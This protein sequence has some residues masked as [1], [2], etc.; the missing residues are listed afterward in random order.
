MGLGAA[1]TPPVQLRMGHNRSRRLLRLSRLARSRLLPNS[2]Q[3]SAAVRLRDAELRQE[4]TKRQGAAFDA[5]VRVV[6][7]EHVDARG[8]LV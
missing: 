4:L 2:S 7:S 6:P 8:V 1:R 3:C 5:D